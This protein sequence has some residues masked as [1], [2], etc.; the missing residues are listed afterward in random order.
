M[1][2]Q[3]SDKSAS[4]A[5]L[6]DSQASQSSAKKRSAR[7]AGLA[8]FFNKAADSSKPT[9]RMKLNDGTAADHQTG[10]K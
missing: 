3:R 5:G 7:Q 1:L 6:A 2:S 4:A 10:K 9:K 8:D